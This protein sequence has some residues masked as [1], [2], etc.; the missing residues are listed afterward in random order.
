MTTKEM[1]R[2]LLKVAAFQQ[3]DNACSCSVAHDL[4]I[5][6]LDRDNLLKKKYKNY[7]ETLHLRIIREPHIR[8]QVSLK[9]LRCRRKTQ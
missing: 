5:R 6:F 1:R 3:L 7:P 8:E 9:C 2:R 4:K